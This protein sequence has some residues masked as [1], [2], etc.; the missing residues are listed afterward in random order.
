MKKSITIGVI[1]VTIVGFLFVSGV[2]EFNQENLDESLQNIPQNIKE[3]GETAQDLAS[4]TSTIIRES[5][6]Q[7]LEHVQ[8]DP[9]HRIVDDIAKIPKQIQEKNPLNEKPI[10]DKHELEIKIHHLTNQYRIQHELEPLSLDDNLSNVARGHSQDMALRDYFDHES[11]EGV[12]PTGRAES[13]GYTCQKIVGN[14]IYSGIAEN[15]F[16]NNLY[17]TVW[18]TAGIP[19]SYEWNTLEEISQSTVDG[20]MNSTGHRENILT[21]TFDREGI[22]VEIAEDDKVYITQNFC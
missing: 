14:L 4:E 12:N 5:I 1:T 17:D 15:I 16:Q 7:R 8:K 21:S 20:W 3:V 2:L 10:I 11:P 22:G 19:T 9:V 18:Y 13:E 6:N